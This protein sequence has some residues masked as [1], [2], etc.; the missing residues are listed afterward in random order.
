MCIRDRPIVS[1]QI[2]NVIDVKAERAKAIYGEDE[3]KVIR[4]SHKNPAI[5][6]IYEDFLGEPNGHKSHHLLHTT[7]VARAKYQD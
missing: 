6:K 2:K 7:Y 1:S 4:K 3:S 5:T